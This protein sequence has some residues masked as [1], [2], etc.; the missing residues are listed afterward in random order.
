VGAVQGLLRETRALDHV[1]ELL[2]RDVPAAR[3]QAAVRADVDPR[4][5]AEDL[6]RVQDPVA[7][8]S[9]DSMKSVWMSVTPRPRIGSYGRSRHF[10]ITSYPGRS[11]PDVPSSVE[12]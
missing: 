2:V 1:A 5:I 11:A 9:G 3:A 8:S 7:T 10:E 6:D 12:S 4:R